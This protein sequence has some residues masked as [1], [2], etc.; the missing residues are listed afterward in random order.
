MC[1]H[2]GDTGAALGVWGGGIPVSVNWRTEP[3]TV[4][5]PVG[6]NYLRGQGECGPFCLI[7]FVLDKCN[8]LF[9]ALLI[10]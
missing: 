10:F 3:R 1:G 2:S 6:V 9:F 8:I 4:L 5:S 7:V